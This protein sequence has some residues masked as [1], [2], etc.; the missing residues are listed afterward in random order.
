[1]TKAYHRNEIFDRDDHVL[2]EGV[3]ARRVFV[4][5]PFLM[6]QLAVDGAA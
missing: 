3:Q 5:P 2:S 6:R 4:C 1:M